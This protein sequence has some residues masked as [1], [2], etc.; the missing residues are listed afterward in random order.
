MSEYGLR[1]STTACCPRET[2]PD[3]CSCPDGCRCHCFDC[4]CATDSV[5][6]ATDSVAAFLAEVQ[7]REALRW[8]QDGTIARLLTAVERVLALAVGANVMLAN[9]ETGHKEAIAW[10]LD[11]DAICEAIQ[12]A[13]RD[14]DGGET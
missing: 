8:Q 4:D 7:E 11:P 5:T 3:S 9:Y 14:A 6:P 13:L 10:D 2:V 12:S 1:Q